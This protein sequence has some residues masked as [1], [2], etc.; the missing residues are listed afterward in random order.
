MLF[1]RLRHDA[2]HP[3]L[4]FDA[5]FDAWRHGNIEG[6]WDEESIVAAYI[7]AVSKG[8]LKVLA[9]MGIST[10]QS[11][12]GAQIFEAVGL[13]LAV[14]SNAAPTGTASRIEGVGFDVFGKVAAPPRGRIPR[15][16]SN[17][18]CRFSRTPVAI[19]R[20]WRRSTRGIRTRSPSS[21]KRLADDKT[22]YARFSKLVNEQTTRECRS[23][24][25]TS[26]HKR[27]FHWKKSIG[28]RYRQAILHGRDELRFDLGRE[29]RIVGGHRWHK[30]NTGEG[31]ED[32]KRFL[33]SPMAIPSGAIKANRLRASL[34]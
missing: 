22:A 24:S 18:T 11:Y 23:A 20:P 6:G 9:K 33:R 10:L 21:S 26:S 27:R 32:Y 14:P 2:I 34:V 29:S 25:S 15:L 3:Y 17:H 8:M 19:T 7:K 4:A 12:K 13:G 28:Q 5:L 16:A 1:G 31:G 30:S